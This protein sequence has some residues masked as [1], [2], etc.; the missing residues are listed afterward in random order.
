MNAAV[1]LDG[2]DQS[3]IEN[4]VPVHGA[5][6]VFIVVNVNLVTQKQVTADHVHQAILVQDVPN[7]VQANGGEINVIKCVP[8]VL[9]QLIGK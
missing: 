1:G 4:V 6:T 5:L 8:Q 9:C 3:V 7:H 2:R